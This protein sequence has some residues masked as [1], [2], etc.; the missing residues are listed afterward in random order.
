M[1]RKRRRGEKPS[2]E[3]CILCLEGPFCRKGRSRAGEGRLSQ[4][5]LHFPAIR[6]HPGTLCPAK[7]YFP[8][9]GWDSGP[10]WASNKNGDFFNVSE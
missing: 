5:G 8:V 2:L 3:C 6:S 4:V 9:P 1:G 7:G 10:G